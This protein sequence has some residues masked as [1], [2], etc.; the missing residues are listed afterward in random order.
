MSAMKRSLRNRLVSVIDRNGDVLFDPVLQPKLHAH[1]VS[2]R[3]HRRAQAERTNEVFRAAVEKR[4]V[5]V[6]APES[7]FFLR[8]AI[9]A[10]G[11]LIG[12]AS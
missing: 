3:A 5:P 10:A 11:R 9:A 1:Q 2:Q 12:V 6:V 4:R 8:R 7:R